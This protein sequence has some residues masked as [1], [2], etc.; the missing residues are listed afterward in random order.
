MSF[1]KLLNFELKRFWKV[2]V[3][4]LLLVVIAQ[5]SVIIYGANHWMDSAYQ[6]MRAHQWTIE[7]YQHVN[8]YI[9]LSSIVMGQGGL[10][11]FASILLG[12][13]ALLLYSLVIWY[14][15][16]RGKNTVIYRMLMLPTSRCNLYFAKLAT[17][18][19]CAW[20]L[21][22]LQL[23]LIPIE[24]L[25]ARAMIPAELYQS[26]TVLDYV[27][28][29]YILKTI[30]PIDLTNFALYYG[31][32]ICG[33]IVLFTAILMER[34]YRLRGILCAILY[35]GIVVGLVVMPYLLGIG[36]YNSYF[37]PEEAIAI[38]LGLIVFISGI[39]LWFSL[40]LIRKKI[41]V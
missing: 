38:Y 33:L 8:G 9:R 1:V 7:Q 11:Y 29:L 5:V 30:I 20:G 37:Y 28:H 35:L 25:I 3:G 18:I 15:D 32:G 6:L 23:L 26:S 39:S 2:Y 12:I 10:F 4:L 19:L 34:S 36:D 21:V 13:A 16:W 27:R 22:A 41:S 40:Y 31:L 17:I 24:S 14:R